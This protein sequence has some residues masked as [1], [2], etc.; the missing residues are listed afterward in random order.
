MFPES[1]QTTVG[2]TNSTL[3]KRST[4]RSTRL[5]GGDLNEN[6]GFLLNG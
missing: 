5:D 2:R 3:A 4:R 1:V 6:T